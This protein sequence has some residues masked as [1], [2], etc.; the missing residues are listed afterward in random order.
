MD[1]FNIHETMVRD[2]N[3]KKKHIQTL[4]EQIELSTKKLDKIEKLVEH[5]K[6]IYQELEALKELKSYPNTENK[7][8]ELE[9]LRNHLKHLSILAEKHQEHIKQTVFSSDILQL[10]K[11]K[12]IK[13]IHPVKLIKNYK[14]YK[15]DVEEYNET[16]RNAKLAEVNI[17]L[18]KETKGVK[19]SSNGTRHYKM[20]NLLINGSY[21]KTDDKYVSTYYLADIPAFLSPYVLFKLMTSSLPFS[22][23]VFI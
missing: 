5:N 10:Q 22:I 3:G 18:A 4:E 12:L 9:I 21:I 23:S 14:K 13:T 11:P 6:D 17:T 1:T 2:I 19:I 7:S 8:K 20:E 16:V 15:V